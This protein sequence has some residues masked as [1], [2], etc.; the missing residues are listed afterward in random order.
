[1]VS[2]DIERAEK[3]LKSAQDLFEQGDIYGVAGLAY[4]AF[5]SATIAL[6]KKMNGYDRKSHFSR[7]KRAKEILKRYRDEIDIIWEL[8]NIDFYGNIVVGEGKREIKK[9]EVEK[10]L[11]IIREMIDEIKE[12]LKNEKS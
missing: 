1:M 7:R 3:L 2:I 8:R 5:E 11:D 6:L 10:C 12:F 4:Q 9:D